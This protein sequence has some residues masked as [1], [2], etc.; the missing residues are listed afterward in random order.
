MDYKEPVG[1]DSKYWSIL[2]SQAEQTLLLNEQ[3]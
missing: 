1:S 2:Q 3:S